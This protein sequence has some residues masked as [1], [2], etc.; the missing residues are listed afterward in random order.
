VEGGLSRCRRREISN[1]MKKYGR[2]KMALER[3]IGAG[4]IR[5]ESICRKKDKKMGRQKGVL[6]GGEGHDEMRARERHKEGVLAEKK[7]HRKR[8]DAV[9]II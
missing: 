3:G 2:K 7:E 6:E 8:G 5:S 4:E 9:L 1:T